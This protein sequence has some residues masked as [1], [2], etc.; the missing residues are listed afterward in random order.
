M[1]LATKNEEHE[2]YLDKLSDSLL[3]MV[4]LAVVV[5]D[6]VLPAHSFVVAASCPALEQLLAEG[7]A[8]HD[9]LGNDDSRPLLLDLSSDGLA[10][11]QAAMMFMYSCAPT[12]GSTLQFSHQRRQ[13]SLQHLHIHME[14]LS[15]P[16]VAMPIS[17][18]T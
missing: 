4:D 7:R 5:N 16:S 8:E 13:S 2:A 14:S 12:K 1:E 18:I 11:V 9:T 6:A 15:C 17:L 3:A 10:C